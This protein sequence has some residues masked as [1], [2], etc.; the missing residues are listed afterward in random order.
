[1][2]HDESFRRSEAL[3]RRRL[4]D[5][6]ILR[7]VGRGGM[8]IVYEA[9]QVSLNRNVALKVLSGVLGLSP[10]AVQRFRREAEAAAR[11]HHTNIVPIYATGEVDGTHYYA[12]ELIQGPSLDQ[13]IRAACLSKEHRV[14]DAPLKIAD[15]T[16]ETVAYAGE[17]IAPQHE[18]PAW[19]SSTISSGSHY[20]DTVA[21]VMADVSDALEYAHRQGIVHRDIKPANLLVS[22]DGKLSLND[23]GLARV[24]EEPGMTATGEMLGTP[25]YMSPEQITAGRT[26]LDHRTDIYSLG[27]T[28]YELL[29]LQRPFTGDRRDQV[30]AQILH[31]EPKPL[32]RINKKVPID[33]ETICLKAMDK[34]PDRRYQTAGAMAEDLRRYVNRFAISA[35]RIGSIGQIVKWCR[36]HPSA[37]AAI[38][39]TVTGVVLAGFFANRANEAEQQRLAEKGQSQRLM[40]AVERKHAL[41]NALI[42]ATSGD[43][44]RANAAINEAE[45]QGASAAQVKVLRGQVAYFHGDFKKALVELEEAT[46]IDPT[47]ASA[48][49][50]LTLTYLHLGDWTRH[51]QELAALDQIQPRTN[52]DFLFKGYAQY[53]IQPRVGLEILDDAVER[54]RSPLARAIRADVRICIAELES[55]IDEAQRAIR[56]IRAAKEYLPDNPLVLSI[57]V[58][59]LGIAANLYR[60]AGKLEQRQALLDEALIDIQ[61]LEHWSSMPYP[62]FAMWCYYSST[63][64]ESQLFEA[65]RRAGESTNDPVFAVRY[66]IA[67]CR[68]GDYSEALRV[69]DRRKWH[70]INGDSL[71]TYILAELQPHDMD[72][73]KQEIKETLLRYGEEKV[74]ESHWSEANSCR[75]MLLL[76]GQSDEAMAGFKSARRRLDSETDEWE[77]RYFDFACGDSTEGELLRVATRRW[78]RFHA[79]HLIA[80]RRLALGDRAGAHDFFRKAEQLRIDGFFP[81]EVVHLYVMRMDRDPNWPPWI[82]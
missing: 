58:L 11:L 43:L 56:D 31:K 55:D 52:E 67:L 19:T 15:N 53:W 50:M 69:L 1:M 33:L 40:A 21:R 18:T 42:A 49:G 14:A 35:R 10:Q 80:L 59:T 12:M 25:A 44:D 26:P 7:E 24:L 9:R 4:G 5:F 17:P 22:P 63:E 20:F 65:A 34:D 72:I 64:N 46:K 36:R 77:R 16:V 75:Q 23:F 71:R 30:L 48:R 79:Y 73:P 68:R 47:S 74:A 39:C 78:H 28:L 45:A 13:V 8:G 41:E 70:D 51:L 6:E 3:A 54:T 32:R 62:A 29:T 57:K 66:A 27:A 81:W 61:G 76:F 37:F 2:V 38:A 82:Q 60:E